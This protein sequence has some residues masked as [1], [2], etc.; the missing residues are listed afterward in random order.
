MAG[1]HCSGWIDGRQN[2]ETFILLMCGTVGRS[3]VVSNDP[4]HRLAVLVVTGKWPDLRRHLRGGRVG[5]A[6]HDRRDR[7]AN[8]H[9]FRR[10]VGNA[11]P[12]Q[13]GAEVGISQAE[14]S[15]LVTLLGDRRLGNEAINTL[16]SSAIGPQAHRVAE[17]F[18]VELPLDIEKLGEVERRQ[19][20]GRIV[21]EHVF[22]TG[23]GGVDPAVFRARVPFVDGRI[24]LRA[25]IGADPG[26]PGDL[27]P[28]VARLDRF[29]DLAVDPA[30]QFPIAVPF[31]HVKEPVGNTHAVVGVLSRDRLLGLAVPIVSYSW[32]TKCVKPCWHIEHAVDIGFRHHIA[33]GRGRR[34]PSAPDSSSGSNSTWPD[35][36]HRP[37]AGLEHGIEALG[38]DLGAGDHR[39]HLLLF[40][41]FPVD[42]FFDIRMVEVQADH[43][44]RSPGRPAGLDRP[45]SP[46]ADLQERH[47][48]G[49][50]AAAG[51][52]FSITA[53]PREIG[54]GPGS[55]FEEPRL[56]D[57]EVH[58][59]VLIDEVV[60]NRLDEAGVGLRMFEGVGRPDDLSQLGI[61][62]KVALRRPRQPV[63]IVQSRC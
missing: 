55:I 1:G 19:V 48:P 13:N 29:A 62:I 15:E 60:F 54:A 31:Q 49:R 34:P 45:G 22:G 42:E 63:G 32:N 14:R 57:P 37:H 43:L 39:R 41:D 5:L 11:L 52:G 44:G 3:P 23:I 18:Q 24:V 61:D 50:P 20:A 38:A 25:G 28:E 56:T 12:H 36:R 7:A 53:Q 40:D 47:E 21:E 17:R 6:R 33:T 35:L 58:D 26:R 16:I 27:V 9:G 8:R 2:R 51:Q 10:I 59:A 46:I 4:Q 30:P